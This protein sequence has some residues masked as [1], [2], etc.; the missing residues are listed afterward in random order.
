MAWVLTKGL[1]TVRSEFNAVFPGRDKASDGSV[2]D[3]AHQTGSSG[4]NPD[5]TGK[6]EYKD[7]DALD[8]VRAI[9]VDRDLVKGSTIDWME[10]VVQYLVKKARAGGYIPFRY[11]IYKGRIWARSDGWKTRTYTGANKHDKHAHFSGDYTQTADNW[12][13]SLGLASVRG[14]TGGGEIGEGDMLVSKGDNGQEVVFWQ[15]VLH[16]LGFGAQ[17]G[18]VDGDYGPKMEAAVNASRAKLSATAGKSTTITGW[19]GFRMLAAMMDKRAGKPGAP[20]AAGA[21]GP[22]GPAGPQG[23]AGPAGPQGPAGQDG[24]LTG[25]LEVQGGTLNVAAAQ[26]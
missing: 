22:A 2:G 3:L 13:G 14:G 6:A 12:T 21:R 7:G 11:I 8:E 25:V 26:Q 23:P 16:D 10:L 18:E 1:T 15:Y 24:T 17:V 19:H 5:R 20:G 9:D 4:H